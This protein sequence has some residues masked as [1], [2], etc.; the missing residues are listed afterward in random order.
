MT[1]FITNILQITGGFFTILFNNPVLLVL[2]ILLI[3]LYIYIFSIF[4]YNYNNGLGFFY[5]H[6]LIKLT[7]NITKLLKNNLFKEISITS[8]KHKKEIN[9]SCGLGYI[10]MGNFRKNNVYKYYSEIID[11]REIYIKIK[12]E[13]NNEIISIVPPSRLSKNTFLNEYKDLNIKE[14]KR[15][16][17]FFKLIKKSLYYNIKY[18]AAKDE[19]FDYIENNKDKIKSDNLEDIMFELINL[20]I[21]KAKCNEAC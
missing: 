14:W 20:N 10:I 21:G 2:F 17:K 5:Y 6:R 15:K 19:L 13:N 4:R 11:D 16:K 9:S 8:Y 1:E 3:I 18:Y 12:D 7:T